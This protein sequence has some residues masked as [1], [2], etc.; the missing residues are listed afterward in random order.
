MFTLYI[1]IICK[2]TVQYNDDEDEGQSLHILKGIQANSK[3]E[4]HPTGFGV[5]QSESN[6]SISEFTR[7]NSKHCQ[8]LL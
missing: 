6:P 3:I 1:L 2:G 7:S 8:A 5:Y 4:E